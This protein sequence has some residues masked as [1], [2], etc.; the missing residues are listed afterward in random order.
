MNKIFILICFSFILSG[1]GKKVSPL[2]F[3]DQTSQPQNSEQ[4]V[5][6][7]LIKSQI[8]SPNC[9]KCHSDVSSENGLQ[10]WITKGDPENSAFYLTIKDGSMPKNAAPLS[11]ADL[12]LIRNYIQQMTV[13]GA[14]VVE[15]PVV[16]PT[17]PT[18]TVSFNQL[19]SEVLSPYRCLNCHS[20]STE[21]GIKKWINI[22]RPERSLLYTSV[23]NGNMPIGNPKVPS[24]KHD[25]I[26]R[27]IEN[28]LATH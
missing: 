13:T 10:K 6:F 7:S 4:Q 5:G 1:C 9:I 19:K 16:V 24:D 23:K 2:T 12:E 18:S 21:N 14:P 22:S 8:L 3:T 17:E 25:L 26:L 15:P 20:V 11:T 27:Y 28:F